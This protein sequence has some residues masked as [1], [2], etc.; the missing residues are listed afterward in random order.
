MPSAG[1]VDSKWTSL[2]LVPGSEV[3]RVLLSA[4]VQ[5]NVPQLCADGVWKL[6]LLLLLVNT[7]KTLSSQNQ[8]TRGV[9]WSP[10]SGE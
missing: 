2:S 1:S 3:L 5:M 6:L 9:F 7:N 10:V 8:G 4:S